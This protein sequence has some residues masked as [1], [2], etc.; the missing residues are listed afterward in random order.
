LF[1]CLQAWQ[2]RF[3]KVVHKRRSALGSTVIIHAASG[4]GGGCGD[5]GGSPCRLVLKVHPSPPLH[6]HPDPHACMPSRPCLRMPTPTPPPLPRRLRR[7]RAGVGTGRRD[8]DRQPWLP[9]TPGR[10][11]A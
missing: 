1:E 6:T 2:M 7:S 8:D 4:S 3:P 11:G 9:S 5:G 10:P